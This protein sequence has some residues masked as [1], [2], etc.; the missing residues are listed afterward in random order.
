MVMA[1]ILARSAWA[2][3][4]RDSNPSA[5]NDAAASGGGDDD[6]ASSRMQSG[7]ETTDGGGGDIIAGMTTR[8]RGG[9]GGVGVVGQAIG[10]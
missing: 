3:L 4:A 1:L 6:N 5:P 9:E 8:G 10:Q 7:G 2:V